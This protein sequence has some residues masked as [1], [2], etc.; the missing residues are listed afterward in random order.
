PG[1]IGQLED[2]ATVTQ[3]DVLVVGG[4]QAQFAAVVVIP[5]IGRAGGKIL[6]KIDIVLV[7]IAQRTVQLQRQQI[8]DQ[9]PAQPGAVA[10]GITILAP[11][12][13][14]VAA[15]QGSAPLLGGLA[16]DD[17]DDA[18]H[19]VRSIVRGHG[20]AVHFDTLD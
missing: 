18:A 19:G 10:A 4:G 8:P 13:T 3:G 7:P 2:V 9:G 12:R 6:G 11:V 16:G 15:G 5:G 17:V 14:G 1:S 20:P